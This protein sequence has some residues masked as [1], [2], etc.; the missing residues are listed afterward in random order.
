[1]SQ[2]QTSKITSKGQITIPYNIRKMLKLNIGSILQFIEQ[3]NSIT[4]VPI[5]NK[6]ENLKGVLPKPAKTLSL[7][8]MD[9]LIKN[10]YDRN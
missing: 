4:L 8:Q 1:M 9:D 3:N 5:S 2:L 6:L 7:E 10:S